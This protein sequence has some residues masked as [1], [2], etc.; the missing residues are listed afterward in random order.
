MLGNWNNTTAESSTECCS[1]WIASSAHQ[2][3]VKSG[4]RFPQATP[5]S[6]HFGLYFF[7]SM[8]SCSTKLCRPA[9]SCVNTCLLFVLNLPAGS[10]IY[11]RVP[12]EWKESVMYLSCCPDLLCG[13]DGFGDKYQR[14]VLPKLTI[15]SVGNGP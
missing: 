14:S 10:Y 9:T 7:N 6:I 2:T 12:E 4:M 1:P 11:N 15:V 5:I 8:A 3:H 13:H